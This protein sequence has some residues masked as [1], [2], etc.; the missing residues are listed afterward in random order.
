MT[1]DRDPPSKLY[2]TDRQGTKCCF[3]IN[4][5][6]VSCGCV[7]K[8]G[9]TPQERTELTA[10][11]KR[12]KYL[13]I[14]AAAVGGGALLAVT[15]DCFSLRPHYLSAAAHW[16]MHTHAG[17]FSTAN[18]MQRS[19]NCVSFILRTSL[20]TGKHDVPSGSM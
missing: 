13:K 8:K 15:G 12:M 5:W 14:G 16:C 6:C 19:A 7:Q 18:H 9:D 17:L 4:C 10:A 20:I 1:K 3:V 11:Q 2:Q